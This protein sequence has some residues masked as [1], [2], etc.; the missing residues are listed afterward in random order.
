MSLRILALCL[1]VSGCSI[2]QPC[3]TSYPSP[4]VDLM[5]SPAP[6]VPIQGEGTVPAQEAAETVVENYG[7]YHETAERLKKLQAWVSKMNDSN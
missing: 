1:L 5:I 6:L 3:E 4:P 2:T 7:I